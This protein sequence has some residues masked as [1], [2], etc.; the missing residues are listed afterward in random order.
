MNKKGLPVWKL[1]YS[2]SVYINLPENTHQ[3]LFTAAD[4]SPMEDFP[5]AFCDFQ[6]TFLKT[7][8]KAT[9]VWLL[10]SSAGHLKYWRYGKMR[11]FRVKLNFAPKN[12]RTCYPELSR[13]TV[14]YFNILSIIWQLLLSVKWRHLF[15]CEV[16]TRPIYGMETNI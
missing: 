9:E 13:F 6:T 7:R 1:A 15:S 3:Y 10:A 12:S 16:K 8:I 14:S 11:E 5:L 2:F 4:N